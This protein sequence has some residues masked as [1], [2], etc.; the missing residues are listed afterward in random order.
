MLQTSCDDVRCAAPGIEAGGA[1]ASRGYV[2]ESPA[3][4]ANATEEISQKLIPEGG[5]RPPKT[6][7]RAAAGTAAF[8]CILMSDTG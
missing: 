8:L 3:P 1:D 4:K 7:C 2:D 6:R 5:Q